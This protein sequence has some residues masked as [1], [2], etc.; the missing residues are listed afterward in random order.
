MVRAL[1]LYDTMAVNVLSMV[2]D[3]VLRLERRRYH[4][5]RLPLTS[6]VCA[7][8]PW[9]V[10]SDQQADG[11]PLV[12]DVGIAILTWDMRGIDRPANSVI[13]AADLAARTCVSL[14]A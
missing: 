9:A 6:G 7:S 10:A 11:V 5:A 3:T 1:Y 2:C 4:T 14:P 8:P 13:I 12:G